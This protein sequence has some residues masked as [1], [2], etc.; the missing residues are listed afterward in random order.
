MSTREFIQ[1]F[2]MCVEAFSWFIW[3]DTQASYSS[4]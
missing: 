1:L 4:R 2:L 3:L